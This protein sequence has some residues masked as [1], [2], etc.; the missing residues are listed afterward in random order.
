MKTKQPA[1]NCVHAI[2]ALSK[3]EHLLRPAGVSFYIPDFISNVC[4]SNAALICYEECHTLVCDY[5]WED[6]TN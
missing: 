6:D 2:L 4:V 5:V 3:L 1:E